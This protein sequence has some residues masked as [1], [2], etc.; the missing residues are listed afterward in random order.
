MKLSITDRFLWDVYDFMSKTGD[1]ARF[2]SQP[3]TMRNYLPGPRNPIFDKYKNKKAFAKLIYYLKRNNYIRVE[4]LKGKQGIILTKAGLGKALKAS[5][6]IKGKVKRK[7]GKWVMLTFDMPAKNKRA[8][9]L[10]TSVLYGLGYKMFQQSVWVTPYD[11]S[12][13]TEE[14]LQFY[15]LDRFV[16]I[17]L[18]EEL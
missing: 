13:K 8:R 11:V 5:F 9:N 1:V 7:D 4:N 2:V 17:F 14:L 18:I 15:N 3:V 12:E 16:K 6:V 10:L